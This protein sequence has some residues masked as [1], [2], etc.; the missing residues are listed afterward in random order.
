MSSPPATGAAP[1]GNGWSFFGKAVAVLAALIGML[2]VGAN[3]FS[4]PSVS[5]VSIQYPAPARVY[6]PPPQAQYQPPPTR[7][8]APPPQAAAQRRAVECRR[9]IPAEDGGGDSREVFA[10]VRRQRDVCMQ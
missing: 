6:A 4:R 2:W 10:G 7:A 3:F 8:V 1:S 9:A 5:V